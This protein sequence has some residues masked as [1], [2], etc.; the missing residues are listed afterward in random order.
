MMKRGKVTVNN[1][2]ITDKFGP[3]HVEFR[4]SD[5]VE[6]TDEALMAKIQTFSFSKK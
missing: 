5:L 1:G 3:F 6:V 4:S 2:A